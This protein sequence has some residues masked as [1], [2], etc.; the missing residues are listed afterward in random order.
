MKRSASGQMNSV[1]KDFLRKR[2][3][4]LSNFRF[5]FLDMTRVMSSF[6]YT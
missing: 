3:N 1:A 4:S 2:S 6:L 5:L